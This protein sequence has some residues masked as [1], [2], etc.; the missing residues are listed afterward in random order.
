MFEVSE[1]RE[2]VLMRAPVSYP[3]HPRHPLLQHRHMSQAR[4]IESVCPI[5]L[6]T[7]TGSGMDMSQASAN[8]N[9]PQDFYQNC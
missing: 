2:L 6:A 1:P 4:A 3:L 8:K 5:S 7:V 9:Q